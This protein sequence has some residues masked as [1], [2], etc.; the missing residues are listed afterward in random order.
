[1]E[2]ELKTAVTSCT[3]QAGVKISLLADGN[4]VVTVLS[5]TEACVLKASSSVKDRCFLGFGPGSWKWV[6]DAQEAEVTRGLS[7][8]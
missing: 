5:D 7:L 2:D 1:M 3:L 6:D 8:V 4:V